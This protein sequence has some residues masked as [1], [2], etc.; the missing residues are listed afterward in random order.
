MRSRAFEK[1]M[2]LRLGKLLL[3]SWAVLRVSW[4]LRV[5]VVYGTEKTNLQYS[6]NANNEGAQK[7]KLY[8]VP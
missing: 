3:I 2:S 4:C 7:Q 1:L 6:K 8:R 5:F